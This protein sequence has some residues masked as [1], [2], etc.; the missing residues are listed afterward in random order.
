MQETSKY[1]NVAYL[2]TDLCDF[3]SDEELHKLTVLSAQMK[4][5]SEFR[6]K[7]LKYLKL[8]YIKAIPSMLKGT[9]KKISFS[10][11]HK[12]I[13]SQMKNN[14]EEKS[15]PFIPEKTRY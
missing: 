7:Y 13:L 14:T 6:K 2:L 9:Y 8:K 4:R 12:N 11:L 3:Y 1:D 15:Y 10:C 5:Y